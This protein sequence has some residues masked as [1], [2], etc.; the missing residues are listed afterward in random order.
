MQREGVSARFT[1]AAMNKRYPLYTLLIEVTKKCNAACDQCGS[2]C[3]IHS[4]EL[5]TKE[6]LLAALRDIKEHLGTD[7]MLNI[8]GGEPLLRRDLFEITAEAA[9]MGFDWG[10]VTNGSLITPQ[11]VEKMRQSGMKTITVSVDGLQETHDSLRHLPGSWDKIMAALPLLR[12]AAFLDH[13]QI[14]FTANRRNV[15][16]VRDLIFHRAR[17][18][19]QR[20]KAR[21]EDRLGLPPLS[22]RP[23][24]EPAVFLLCRKI[25]RLHSG[26]RRYFRL[27]QRRAPA[28][29]HPGQYFKGQLQRR[30][31]QPLRIL[32]QPPAAADLRGLRPSGSL[33]GRFPAHAGF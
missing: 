6:Q 19:A 33:Q 31:G 27:P 1:V 4:E 3:D 15:H 23:A 16:P 12:Q 30:V 17:E 14:T 5:L 11:T 29:T 20:R 8:T 18:P 21:T 2:R 13:I 10:M 7:T 9:A 32:P 26:Q 22:G 24:R 28:G 25:H